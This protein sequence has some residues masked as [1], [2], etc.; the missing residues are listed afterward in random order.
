M[1]KPDWKP[2]RRE[3]SNHEETRRRAFAARLTDAIEQ[4]RAD[5]ADQF[6]AEALLDAICRFDED[7]DLDLEFLA[8]ALC[9][10]VDLE[11]R[12]ASEEAERK[13]QRAA[14]E[15]L[16]RRVKEVAAQLGVEESKAREVFKSVGSRDWTEDVERFDPADWKFRF[17]YL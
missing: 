13:Q 11:A 5:F 10:K 7:G 16:W 17:R 4:V 2:D 15:E 8:D 14:R 3:E 12:C 9:E 1:P 6:F